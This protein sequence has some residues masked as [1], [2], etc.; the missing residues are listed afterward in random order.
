M[1]NYQKYKW[2]PELAVI[3]C[4]SFK[5]R[6]WTKLIK[7][8]KHVW[9]F[10]SLDNIFGIR[11]FFGKSKS[12]PISSEKFRLEFATNVDD[13]GNNDDD[14]NDD[15]NN[16]DVNNND[17]NNDDVNNDDDNDDDVD[18]TTQRLEVVFVADAD[19]DDNDVLIWRDV[20]KKI[21]MRKNYRAVENLP[22]P[23]H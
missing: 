18:L 12:V 15:D 2:A 20:L 5:I 14:N 23:N 1:Q 17:D 4:A 16:D 21:Q 13:D 9:L 8:L 11:T 22:K 7:F 10:K 19:A 3:F 6:T